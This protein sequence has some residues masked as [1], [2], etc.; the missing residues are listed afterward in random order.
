MP[1]IRPGRGLIGVN[2]SVSVFSV[3]DILTASGIVSGGGGSAYDSAAQDEAFDALYDSAHASHGTSGTIYVRKTGNDSTGNGTSGNPYLTIGRGLQALNAA[4]GG[5]TLIVGDGTY[6]G[7]A[8]WISTAQQSI[9]NGTSGNMTVIRTENRFGVRIVESSAPSIYSDAAINLSGKQYIWVDGFI[10][11]STFTASTGDG[12]DDCVVS[13]AGATNC[14]ATRIIAKR[15]SCD[16]YGS[17]F[18]YGDGNVLEDCHHFGSSRYAFYGGTGGGSS[19]AGNSVLRRCTSYM[20]FGPVFEPSS[21]FAFYGSNTSA[22]AD[23]KDVA[24]LNCYEI[25]SPHLPKKAAENA[26]DLKWG[27]WYHPKSVR[28]VEHIGCGVINCG[29]EYGGIRF[30]N[31]GG[32]GAALGSIID[33]FVTGFNNGSASGAACF[34]KSDS[35]GSIPIINCTGTDAPGGFSSGSGFTLTDNLTSS[36]TYPVVRQSGNGAE[37]KYCIGKFLSFRD[38]PDYK[39]VQ[40]SMKLWPFPYEAAL[41]SLW[42]E[43]ITRVTQDVPTGVSTSTNPASGTALGGG[44]NTFTKR[45]WEENGTATPSF[46]DGAGVY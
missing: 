4:G 8:E 10:V 30:D 33:C 12:N 19:A 39:T 25:D 5:R 36:V 28:N 41:A 6:T 22:Y 26:E 37:Q 13:L 23:C 29:G 3:N 2:G 18:M 43:T 15:K 11:E 40:T 32:A 20:P 44:S 14:R 31:Y 45:V 17:S 9:P 34:S 24:F 21:S 7:P 35:N 1:F 27:S 16:Q 42:D 38:D 46:A